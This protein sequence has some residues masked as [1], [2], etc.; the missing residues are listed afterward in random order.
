MFDYTIFVS[1]SPTIACQI[2][3]F[4]FF[5]LLGPTISWWLFTISQRRGIP[6]N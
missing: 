6:L 5:Y 3:I 1:A 2:I 4:S